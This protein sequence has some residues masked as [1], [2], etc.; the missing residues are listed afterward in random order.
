MKA[1]PPREPSPESRT[2]Q[3]LALLREVAPSRLCV[4]L[5]ARRTKMPRHVAAARLCDLRDRGYA[6]SYEDGPSQVWAAT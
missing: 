5:I 6:V 4:T 2:G 3:C 1:R